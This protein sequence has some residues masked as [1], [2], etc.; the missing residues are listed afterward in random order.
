MANGLHLPSRSSFNEIFLSDSSLNESS[1]IKLESLYAFSQERILS[2]VG[3]SSGSMTSTWGLKSSLNRGRSCRLADMLGPFGPAVVIQPNLHL[4]GCGIWA[5][6][7]RRF[8]ARRISPD[9]GTLG[10]EGSVIAAKSRG[11]PPLK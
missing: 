1:F 6:S 8:I 3:R 2:M 7:P 5:D 10:A 4:V 9:R 11:F